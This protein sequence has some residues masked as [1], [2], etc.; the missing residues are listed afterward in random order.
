MAVKKTVEEIVDALVIAVFSLIFISMAS[1]FVDAV[2]KTPSANTLANFIRVM[3]DANQDNDARYP[4]ILN[5]DNDYTMFGLGV[6]MI[7]VQN[8]GDLPDNAASKIIKK[9]CETGKTCLCIMRVSDCNKIIIP[10]QRNWELMGA[11]SGY[12]ENTELQLLY[13][14]NSN[15]KEFTYNLLTYDDCA[16]RRYLTQIINCAQTSE[17]ENLILTSNNKPVLLFPSDRI[18]IKDADRIELVL[19]K[20]SGLNGEK[21]ISIEGRTVTYTK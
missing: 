21:M 9:T 8:T 6:Y 17:D 20:V 1:P 10:S 16:K 15:L 2:L 7:Q 3:D 4:L 11:F 12:A 19:R 18:E 5:K 13:D 14:S